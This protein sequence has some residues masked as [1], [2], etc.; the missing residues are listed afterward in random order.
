[1]SAR[2]HWAVVEVPV[3]PAPVSD[4]R[5]LAARAATDPEAFA[6]LYRLYVGRIHAFA[7][8]RSGSA[9]VAEDV[10][11]ATFERALRNMD[12]F[13]WRGGGFRPWLFQIA[14]NELAEHYR[15]RSRAASVRSERG[16]RLLVGSGTAPDTSLLAEGGDD[17]VDGLRQA[18][19]TLPARYQQ[20]VS[21]RYLAELSPAE[22]ARAMGCSKGAMA[23][24]LHRA[25]GAL[26][27]AMVAG[28]AA[29]NLEA[30]Q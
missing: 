21:L 9:E 18:L 20:A 3:E 10:T 1:M 24:T 5:E 14:A 28:A 13:R 17:R 26:R 11:S 7:Y 25:L 27:K 16:L 2:A 23:V 30:G 29:A 12:G 15:R 6:E 22:S 19:S 8:R 4:E